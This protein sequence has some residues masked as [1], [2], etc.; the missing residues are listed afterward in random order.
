MDKPSLI[1]KV[2]SAKAD[3]S[4]KKELEDWL[5][6]GE[7][8]KIEFNDIKLIWENSTDPDQS[9]PKN[10]FREGL[11]KIKALMQTKLK[12]REQSKR[13]WALLILL[14]LGILLFTFVFFLKPQR[15]KPSGHLQFNNVSLGQVLE[16]LESE[17]GVH[18]E[19]ADRKLNTC[20]FTGIFY[21]TKNVKDVLQL[22]D[23][24]LNLKY[25]IT[26]EGQYLLTGPGCVPVQ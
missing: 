24:A 4:E 9:L 5:E 18:I 22:L 21:Q 1:Y 14:L 26:G 16:T 15:H 11:T 20:L 7:E 12:K 13:T 17:Y 3:E 10:Q 6:Q 19:L 8:N 2:L 25:T 23:E